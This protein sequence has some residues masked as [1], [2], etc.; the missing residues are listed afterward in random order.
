MIFNTRAMLVAVFV[1]TL[2]VIVGVYVTNLSTIESTGINSTAR[3]KPMPRFT[4][5][6]LEIAI[7]TDPVIPKVG[8]N[9]LIIDLR[10]LEG[11]PVIGAAVDAY[12]EMAA[13]GAMPAMRAPAGLQEVAPGRF[14]GAVNLSMRGEWPLTV[15]IS[16]TRFGDKR[17]L[18]DLATDREGLI[19][20][21]GGIAV[22]G[23]P[24]LLDDENVITIDSRR[25]QMIGVETDTAT[26]RDLVK[27]IRAVGEITFDERLLSN[28]TLKF[29]GYIGDLKADYVG[30]EVHQDQVLFTVYSPELF[31]AQQ[32]YLETLKRRGARTGTGLLEAARRRLLLWDMT[33]Q[34]IEI[35]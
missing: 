29:D 30:T 28:I 8:D 10:D 31:A 27:S 35:L 7:R 32:A 11:N 25:R 5:G 13:M 19:I 34:D 15:R 20:A 3:N 4:A 22:G 9:A 6:N 26:H 1:V 18:F 12:A 24:L 17:L 16:N 14:E 2:V 33:P 21:S 23:A